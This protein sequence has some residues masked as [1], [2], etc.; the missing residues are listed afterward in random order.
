VL[1]VYVLCFCGLSVCFVLFVVCLLFVWYPHWHQHEP[2]RVCR[3]GAGRRFGGPL[4]P[5]SYGGAAL[6]LDEKRGNKTLHKNEKT[7]TS[8]ICNADSGLLVALSVPRSAFL[9]DFQPAGASRSLQGSKLEKRGHS[10][11]V[12]M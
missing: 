5:R 12:S 9:A 4:Q 7:K 8:S 11:N 2:T 6:G 1:Y 10:H 3:P